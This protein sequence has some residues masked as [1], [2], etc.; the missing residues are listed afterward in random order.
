MP[1]LP[2]QRTS[3]SRKR[4]RSSHH[5]LSRPKLVQCSNCSEM[6][7]PHHVCQNCGYYQGREVVSSED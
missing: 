5:A 4:R 6:R 7:R 2:K 1:P 3:K